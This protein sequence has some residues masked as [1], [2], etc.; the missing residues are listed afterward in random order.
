MR[1]DLLQ[2]NEELR[3]VNHSVRNWFASAAFLLLILAA[4]ALYWRIHS[5]ITLASSDTLVRADMDN[6]T[7][8]VALGDG[9]D[10]AL[11]VTLEQTPYLNLL[12]RD[13]VR[14]TLR[15]LGLGEDSR[16]TPQIAL[17]VCRR[18][19]SR[20][21][22]SAFIA[23]VGN[24]YRVGL[25]AMDCQSGK[26]LAQVANEAA[27]REDIVRTLGLSAVQLRG[28][29]GESKD[30]L[31]KFNQP[32]DQATSSSP[33]ALAFLALG[34]KKQLSGD[35]P[36]ALGE[37]EGALEKDPSF[38]L[39]YAAAGSG[40]KWL[41]I[42][43]L[44]SLN[45]SKAFNLRHQLTIPAQFQV[46]TLYY[47]GRNEWDKACHIGEEWVEV[48]PRDV[49]AR[50]NF[51]ACLNYLGRHDEALVQAREAARLLPSDPTLNNL[52]TTAIDAQRFDEA[53]EAYDDAMS[54]GLHSLEWHKNHAWLAFLLKDESGM[55]T[56]W[57]WALQDQVRGPMVFN[58]ESKAEGFHGRSRNADRLAQIAAESLMKAGFSSDAAPIEIDA[59]LR[60]AENGNPKQA[61]LLVTDALRKSR[62]RVSLIYSAFT[63]A[64][65]G[66]TEQSRK[67]AEEWS[68][69][70]PDEFSGQAFLLPC[71]RAAIKLSENDP[72]AAIKILRPVEPYDLAIT[73]AFDYVYPAY[74]R[75]LAYLQLKQGGL[76]ADQF[77]K[78]L[79]HSG[80]GAGFVTGSLSVLQLARAQMLL[81]DA[82]AAR[83]SY[84]DFLTLWK[85]A[86]PNLP[87]YREAKREY[88]RLRNSQ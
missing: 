53:K 32:L 48:F 65:A 35:I 26:M 19:N 66:N 43:A 15:V 8:D 9:M 56:E 40:N 44:A 11:Q 75:G 60:E 71:V 17:Q 46:E 69:N 55:Q 42:D 80:I 63:F 14:E 31:R 29:L 41:G 81:H 23:D 5:R 61:Q 62:D 45:F 39:A 70:F 22:I 24:R 49:I 76:A 7:A 6:Q 51:G 59:A 86:D 74:L 1:K 2:V 3:P 30:S 47:E 36:A 79:D 25:S 58:L 64:R 27:V 68:Q 85:D 73:D 84:E 28:E 4:G 67:L 38:A 13:K 37:Y 10:L 82:G 16:V 87:I 33:D 34:Y 12:G 18:T 72:S 54:R 20:A 57:A 50:I 78:V 21:V 77:R 52:L 88:A 83:K